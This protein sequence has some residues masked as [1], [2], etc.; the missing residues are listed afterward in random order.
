MSMPLRMKH[1]NRKYI[2]SFVGGLPIITGIAFGQ[3]LW[4]HAYNSARNYFNAYNNPNSNTNSNKGTA[5]RY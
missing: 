5:L 1:S 4:N 2:L 3:N